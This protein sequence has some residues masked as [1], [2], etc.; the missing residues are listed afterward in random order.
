MNRRKLLSTV[1]ILS[2]V[3][4]LAST[5][6]EAALPEGSPSLPALREAAGKRWAASGF[7]TRRMA[8]GGT[9]L[10][11]ALAGKGPPVV[12]LHG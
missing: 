6:A 12:R 1:G 5:T 2:L 3:E 7:A 9:T 11:V 10:Y 8:V 4:P